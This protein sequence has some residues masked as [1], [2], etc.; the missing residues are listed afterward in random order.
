MSKIFCPGQNVFGPFHWWFYP[1]DSGLALKFLS[2]PRYW[3]FS[4]III[5]YEHDGTLLHVPYLWKGD[6]NLGI[7]YINLDK[8]AKGHLKLGINS[9]RW[10]LFLARFTPVVGILYKLLEQFSV[11]SFKTRYWQSFLT[12]SSPNQYIVN[13]HLS[14]DFCCN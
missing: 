3:I 13:V 1:I 10:Q 7:H 2:K 5:Y 6:E 14:G 8:M 11:W 4:A 12:P 9:G